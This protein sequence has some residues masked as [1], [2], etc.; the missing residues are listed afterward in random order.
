MYKLALLGPP[1]YLNFDLR[2]Q[3]E[4]RLDYPPFGAGTACF[5]AVKYI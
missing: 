2:L 4:R 1:Y 5:M 3:W